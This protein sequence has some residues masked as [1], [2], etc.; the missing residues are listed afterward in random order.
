MSTY[1][2]RV[3]A[4]ARRCP[5]CGVRLGYFDG[6]SGPEYLYCEDCF[7]ETYDPVSGIKLGEIE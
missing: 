3:P 5:R 1:E 7:T 4:R 2:A 6:N